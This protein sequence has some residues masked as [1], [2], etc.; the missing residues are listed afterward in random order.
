[1]GDSG[2]YRIP[3]YHLEV[4]HLIAEDEAWWANMFRENHWKILMMTD[5]ILGL[6]DNWA[7]RKKG[8]CVFVL[9]WKI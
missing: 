5:H 9:E 6:K 8:N 4:S 7:D 1:M 2:I 3:E